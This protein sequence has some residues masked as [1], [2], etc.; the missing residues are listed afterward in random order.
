MDQAPDRTA[1]WGWFVSD[2]AHW[3][4][5]GFGGLMVD[6][7]ETGETIG[8]VA[9]NNGPTFP[10]TEIGWMLYEGAERKGFATEAAMAL[11]EWAYRANLLKTLV[12]YIDPENSASIRLAERLGAVPD[13]DAERRTP[14]DLV[15]RHPSPE[16]A[17][18]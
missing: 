2:V 16:E 12:S 18:I 3:T 10:E 7:R 5:F 8:E 11:R 4:L 13:H 6:V 14:E 1:A 17:L 15:Y 9:I